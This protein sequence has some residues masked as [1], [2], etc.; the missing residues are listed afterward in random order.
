MTPAR[1]PRILV[2]F[3][4]LLAAFA[5]LL[6]LPGQVD[7]ASTVNAPSSATLVTT[8]ALAQLN[9]KQGECFPFVQRVMKA[10][11]GRSIGSD[12]RLGYI[13]AG[14]IEVPL[15]AAQVGD[16]LQL[17]DDK[18]TTPSADYPGMHTAIV[19]QNY[20][21]GKFQVVDSNAQYDGVVR[22]RDYEPMVVAARYS[23][24]SVHAYH[25][26]DTPIPAN[27]TG[28]GAGVGGA[29]IGSASTSSGP[30]IALAPG[31]TA[32]VVAD[33][34]CL[35]VR[36]LPSLSGTV[37]SCVSS[38][39]AMSVL[40]GAADAEGYHWVRVSGGGVTGW[41]VDQFLRG[42]AAAS[43]PAAPEPPSTTG[44]IVGG[45]IPTAGFG[46]VVYGGGSKDA[47]LTASSCPKISAAFWASTA[48]GSFVTYIPAASVAVVNAGWDS[49]FPSG[50]PASTALIGRCS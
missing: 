27:A 20:G 14:A 23:N 19:L 3:A 24:I 35:R 45:S 16:V 29:G 31:V 50:V 6:V 28:S 21:A 48:D 33:G 41:A 39:S 49:Q 43:A 15:I 2:V 9:S 26:I 4:A 12:Y 34:D 37:F 38:G 32:T 17:I 18:N 46:L 7:A 42:I 22:Q 10:A 25:L 1:T 40:G 11:I 44:K 8:S 5:F 36:S 47:L 13:Q 30:A